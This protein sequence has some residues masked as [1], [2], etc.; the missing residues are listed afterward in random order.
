MPASVDVT[1]VVCTRNRPA[2]LDTA[3]ASLQQ[4][5][6]PECAILVVDSASE[7]VET[8]DVAARYATRYLR[9]DIKGLSIARNAGLYSSH[10]EIVVFTDDDCL[11]VEGWIPPILAQFEDP[12]VDAVAGR[13][14]DG[15]LDD[16]PQTRRFSDPLDAMDAGH[17]ALMAFRRLRPLELGGFD[18]VLGAGRALAGAEDLDM[19]LRTARAGGVVVFEPASAVRH[20]HERQGDDYTALLRGYGRGLGGLI[21]KWR[22]VDPALGRA[23][24][25]RTWRRATLRHLRA[26]GDRRARDGE[27][28]F[29]MGLR[30]GMRTAASIPVSGE[31][32]VDL[33]RPAA[34]PIPTPRL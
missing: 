34:R 29:R 26:L 9:V 12:R 27:A 23:I 14:L 28:A 2:F 20:D 4:S 18:E 33:E 19:F 5:S 31:V 17:G 13:M 30:E 16:H 32:L 21:A 11:A 7:T 22:R 6:P 25:T 24:A 10:T 8:R 3:L 1:I 15:I